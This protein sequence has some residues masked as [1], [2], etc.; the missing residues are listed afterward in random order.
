MPFE[1]FIVLSFFSSTTLCVLFTLTIVHHAA[2][3]VY[4]TSKTKKKARDVFI[5]LP[6]LPTHSH[7]IIDSL[8]KKPSPKKKIAYRSSLSVSFIFS[9]IYSLTIPLFFISIYDSD[10]YSALFLSTGA[11]P[12]SLSVLYIVVV[13]KMIKNRTFD[14]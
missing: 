4:I 2:I 10:M 5:N 11:F 9:A 3:Y 6:M 7:N 12:F 14:G 8:E 1:L 13:I